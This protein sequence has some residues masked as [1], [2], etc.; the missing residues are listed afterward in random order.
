MKENLETLVAKM[1]SSVKK[2]RM[3]ALEKL[4][5]ANCCEKISPQVKIEVGFYLANHFFMRGVRERERI[6]KF[7]DAWFS[8]EPHSKLSQRLLSLIM[9]ET[10]ENIRNNL[11]A[12]AINTMPPERLIQHLQIPTKDR[13]CQDYELL[14]LVEAIERR[15]KDDSFTEKQID[16]LI[17]ALKVAQMYILPH[18]SKPFLWH[19]ENILERAKLLKLKIMR[20]SYF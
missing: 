3:K 15:L 12:A 11:M 14:M 17:E 5:N 10:N 9:E 20:G 7:L 2:E 1:K 8:N 19:L 13:L 4:E 6:A 18:I 16:E